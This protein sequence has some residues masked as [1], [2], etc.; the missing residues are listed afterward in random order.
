VRSGGTIIAYRDGCLNLYGGTILP[1]DGVSSGGA[2]CTFTEFN[3]YGGTVQGGKVTNSGGAIYLAKQTGMDA[4]A[5]NI[6]GGSIIAGSS[7]LTGDCI[8]V[9]SG[10]VT[11]SGSPEV[12]QIRFKSASAD[13]F[14]VDATDVPFTGK[15]ALLYAG[16]LAIGTDVGNL[17]GDKGM[18]DASIVIAGTEHIVASEETNLVVSGVAA[19]IC[20]DNTI[21]GAYNSLD[22]AM[23]AY[24]YNGNAR[25]YIKLAGN[26]ASDTVISRD[27]YLDLNGC[28][29]T[30]DITVQNEAVLYCMDSKTNDY[31]V[32]DGDYGVIS[33][34]IS[35]NIQGIPVETVGATES[36][37]DSHRA[38]YLKVTEETGVSFHRVN[39]KIS[40]MALRC[41]CVGLYYRSNFIGDEVVA[42]NVESFGIAFSV[43]EPPTAANL[44]TVCA[45]SLNRGFLSGS[46]G[47]TSVQ[48]GVLLREVMKKSL[49]DI[50]NE[51]RANIPIFG[52]A[53]I[54]TED[55]YVFGSVVNR[56][57]KSQ[58]VAVNGIYDQLTDLQRD[59]V[60]EMYGQY[61]S[62]M[63]EWNIDKISEGYR[64]K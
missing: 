39:L 57:L 17:L 56:S 9:N 2:V 62:V 15:I 63:K 10:T 32:S 48:T 24:S 36:T 20:S 37:Q 51:Y 12:D 41:A 25:N 14:V 40:H 26:I 11:V 34:T 16:E 35:G 53:Y 42:A 61:E 64:T 18:D 45:Y 33:G 54:K 23:E 7:D 6:Y 13:S 60:L 49:D 59:S 50:E 47:N 43:S 38:G 8:S 3:I 19:W 44:N 28:D 22:S 1:C 4:G 55:G 5:L 29:L 31:T 52:R 58:I 30:G 21:V 46:N 27:I